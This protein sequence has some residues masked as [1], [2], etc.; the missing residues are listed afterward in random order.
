MCLKSPLDIVNY[1]FISGRAL[2]IQPSHKDG[3][4]TGERG[5]SGLQFSSTTVNPQ[6]NPCRKAKSVLAGLGVSFRAQKDLA[7]GTRSH[8]NSSSTWGNHLLRWLHQIVCQDTWSC[9]CYGTTSWHVLW[10]SSL[11]FSSEKVTFRKNRAS[12]S[13]VLKAI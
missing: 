3:F 10:L 9:S 4:A 6:R 5:V 13:S 11:F 2:A 12:E 1:Y 8:N 7:Q